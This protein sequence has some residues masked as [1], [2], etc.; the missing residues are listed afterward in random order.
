QTEGLTEEQ[1][2]CKNGHGRP[3]QLVH[4]HFKRSSRSWSAAV[5]DPVSHA[6]QQRPACF[7]IALLAAHPK[8]ELRQLRLAFGASHRGAE[9][10]NAPG[11][12]LYCHFSRERWVNGAAI[13]PHLAA[14]WMPQKPISAQGRFFNSV[15]MGKHREDQF[16]LSR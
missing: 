3:Q 4:Y 1:S 13:N 9:E 5:N 7:Q 16:H 11:V 10:T 12:R 15:G 8:G 2:L 14:L 6:F